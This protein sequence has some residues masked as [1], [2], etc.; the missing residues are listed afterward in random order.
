MKP[1]SG[2]IWKSHM[3]WV[4]EE[5]LP[6]RKRGAMVGRWWKK[7]WGAGRTFP[8]RRALLSFPVADGETMQSCYLIF[9]RSHSQWRSRWDLNIN[10]LHSA[11]LQKIWGNMGWSGWSHVAYLFLEGNCSQKIDLKIE[12]LSVSESRQEGVI[13][14]SLPSPGDAEKCWW[15]RASVCRRGSQLRVHRWEAAPPD[16]V[17]KT[18]DL[19]ESHG[20]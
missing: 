15:E 11:E 18:L 10:F 9:W 17:L 13:P 7:L 2:C 20:E 5:Q 3:D 8:Y 1:S 19:E 12:H 14:C 4:G 6:K 16:C